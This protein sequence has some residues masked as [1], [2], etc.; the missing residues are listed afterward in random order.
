MRI[1]VDAM[2]SDDHPTPDVE[3]AVLAAREFGETIVLVGD[4]SQIEAELAKHRTTGLAIEVQHASQQ[5]TMTDK[6]SEVVKG[7]PDSSMHVGLQMVRDGKADAFVSAGNT[8]GILGIAMLRR[9][10]VGRIPGVKRPAMGVVFPIETRPL[11]MDNG[12]NADCKPDWLV[13]FALMSSLYVERVLEIENPRV[14]LISNGEEEGKGNQLIKE[15]IPLLQASGLNYV[16]NVEPK[17]F[18]HGEAHI[19]ITDGF[20]GNIMMKTAE[21]IAGYMSNLIR[22]SLM[23]NPLTIIGGLLAR[24]AFAKVRGR[25]NPDEVGGA[26]L[27]GVNGVVIIAHGRSNAYAIKQAIGQAR[28]MVEKEVVA[29]IT[30]GMKAV[31]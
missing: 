19:G 1:V 12:A 20:T 16:G 14:A 6:P 24:A 21:A 10:G 9:I 31:S 26:P 15:T 8:G 30:E 3:G 13:Q 11:L 7:K 22:D 25:L 17:E 2:G 28:R 23:A 18:M 4:Q 29:A 5:V 27:L